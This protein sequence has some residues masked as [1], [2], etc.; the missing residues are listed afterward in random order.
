MDIIGEGTLD[1]N[2]S[3]SHGNMAVM[4]IVDDYSISA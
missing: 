1:R 2:L 4:M 3:N